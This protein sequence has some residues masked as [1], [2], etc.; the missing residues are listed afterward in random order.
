[1]FG[2]NGISFP[3]FC[4]SYRKLC[5]GTRGRFCAFGHIL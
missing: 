5:G 2:H 4:L 1:M 3:L